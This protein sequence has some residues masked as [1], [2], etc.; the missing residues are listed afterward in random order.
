MS[1]AHDVS[2]SE[3]KLDLLE[4]ISRLR[5][6]QQRSGGD[7]DVAQVRARLERELGDAVSRR[8]A[9][10]FLGVSHTALGRWIKRGDLPLVHTPT[11]RDQV[12]VA[13]LLD[14]REGVEEERRRGRRRRHLLEPVLTEGRD[15]AKKMR[16]GSLVADRDDADGHD[17][18]DRRALAYH[19]AVARCLN[20][21]KVDEALHRVWR[22]RDEGK[23][24][25]RY[26]EAWE[27]V[28][29][30]PV[31]EVRR[32]LGEDSD[33]ARDLRQNTP[34]AGMLSEA[35]RRRILERVR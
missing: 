27:R 25:P 2:T 31:A 9:A 30:R 29:A 16:V 4:D 12:P 6:S 5:R 20:R 1:Y 8:L 24:D 22:W 18:A 32:K 10:R 14:L 35:E 13:A 11:G 19:R 3:R 17:R 15:R 28:L 21:A 34:F 7:R 26:A 23:L 33:D